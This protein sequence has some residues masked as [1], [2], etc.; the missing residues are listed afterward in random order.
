MTNNTNLKV[1]LHERTFE[2]KFNEFMNYKEYISLYFFSQRMRLE[3]SHK[4]DCLTLLTNAV[5]YKCASIGNLREIAK[6]TH[7]AIKKH[8]DT[9]WIG[10]FKLTWLRKTKAEK[11][12]NKYFD[13]NYNIKA[14]KS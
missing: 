3:K 1:Q 9:G 11:E 5:D 10:F 13:E 4:R 2:S 14:L 8:R 12:F 7:D 6:H